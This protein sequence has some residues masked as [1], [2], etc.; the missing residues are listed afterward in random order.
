MKKDKKR[1]RRLL[2]LSLVTALLFG[3]LSMS[4]FAWFTSNRTVTVSPIQVNVAAAGGIQISADGTTWKS[5]VNQTELLA[6]NGL[7]PAAIN[8]I[9]AELAAVSSGLNVDASGLMEMYS[10]SVTARPLDGQYILTTTKSTEVHGT[11]GE[12]IAFDLF[13]RL[14]SSSSSQ[15]YLTTTSGVVASGADSGIKNASRIA[16]VNKGNVVIGTPL[17]G[18]QAINSGVASPVVLWEPNYN[19]HTAPAILHANDTYGL[20]VTD[21]GA[22][23]AYDGVIAPITALN[24]VLVAVS[25]AVSYPAY[26]KDVTPTF[27]TDVNYS[28]VTNFQQAFTLSPGTITKMRVYMWM[29]GQDVDCENSASGAMAIFNLQLSL[30]DQ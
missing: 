24:D 12:F 2:L 25:N 11:A 30:N 16:F 8:Q 29:E 21:G 28:G 5:M 15:I 1:R 23:V 13:F 6:A 3:L 7:Y 18:I 10:G 20:T 27:T 26:F 22:Q 4:T 19:S 17:A 14:D 9:P